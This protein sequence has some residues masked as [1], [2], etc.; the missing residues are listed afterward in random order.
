METVAGKDLL[1]GHG[2]TPL[3]EVQD[4]HVSYRADPRQSCVARLKN[5]P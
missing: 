5:W 2:M 3:L 1:D 4:L